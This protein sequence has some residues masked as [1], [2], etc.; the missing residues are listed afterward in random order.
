MYL[1]IYMFCATCEG[2]S[3]SGSSDS[4]CQHSGQTHTHTLTYT[5]THT[6][7]GPLEYQFI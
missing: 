6:P 2:S 7:S 1:N 4:T 3:L 5:C